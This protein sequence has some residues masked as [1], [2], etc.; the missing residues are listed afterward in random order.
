MLKGALMSP[1]VG[2]AYRLFECYGQQP[3]P[4]ELQPLHNVGPQKVL[5]F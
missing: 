1:V 5:A 3:S 4:K 2:V